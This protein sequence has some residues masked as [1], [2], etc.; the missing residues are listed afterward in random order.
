MLCLDQRGVP[1]HILPLYSWCGREYET[2]RS[3]ELQILIVLQ[4]IPF[5]VFCN[6]S[7]EAE[8]W[9]CSIIAL[10]ALEGAPLTPHSWVVL[11]FRR[12]TLGCQIQAIWDPIS[13]YSSIMFND[14]LSGTLG[15]HLLHC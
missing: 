13:D 1:Q 5:I 12:G 9:E 3:E 14:V 7:P 11:D 4:Y 15:I 6:K 8:L 2:L 10:V